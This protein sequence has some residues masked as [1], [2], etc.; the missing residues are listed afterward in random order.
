MPKGKKIEQ[1][2]TLPLPLSYPYFATFC[3]LLS[4]S[5]AIFVNYGLMLFVD[6][7]PSKTLGIFSTER[8]DFGIK[9]FGMFG[10]DAD[11]GVF[12]NPEVTPAKKRVKG[13]G[14]ARAD[15]KRENLREKVARSHA[16]IVR[17]GAR[18]SEPSW[19]YY[20]PYETMNAWLVAAGGMFVTGLL[21]LM[22]RMFSYKKFM[23]AQ[24]MQS[25]GGGV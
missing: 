15:V 23:D 14:E 18:N 20:L 4:L 16:P 1:I 13:K 24:A 25:A 9:T 21:M 12:Y 7:L 3:I 2:L 11:T 10:N 19:R 5:V 6:E 8:R 17:G 22:F